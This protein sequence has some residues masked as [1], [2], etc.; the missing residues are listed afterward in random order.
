MQF[1]LSNYKK[2]TFRDIKNVKQSACIFFY[3][4]CYYYQSQIIFF[5]SFLSVLSMRIYQ[6]LKYL[7][8][9]KKY[10]ELGISSNNKGKWSMQTNMKKQQV[11]K[12]KVK[13]LSRV[14]LFVTR[15]L[16]PTSFL[17][18][19]DSEGK[20]TGVGCHFLLQGN[21]PDPGIKPRSPALQTD[22][23]TSE[24]PGKPATAQLHT[25]HMLVKKCSKFSKPD[26]SSM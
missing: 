21:L 14:R 15:G 10:S 25:S 12:V 1:Y 7:Q 4:I 11:K 9:F 3:N 23:L 20:N 19:W 22:A 5:F 17:H 6:Y 16:Q 24:L 8:N 26:F 2:S 13:S 18:P